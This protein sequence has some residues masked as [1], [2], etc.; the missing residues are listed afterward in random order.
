MTMTRI[1][2][3]PAKTVGLDSPPMLGRAAR[4]GFILF[5][6][7]LLNVFLPG[8]TRGMVTL[9]G[10]APSCHEKV[11]TSCCSGGAKTADNKGEPTSSDRARC[12]VCFFAARVC[13]ITPYE[14]R[15]TEMGLCEILPVAQPIIAPTIALH[16]PYLGRAPPIA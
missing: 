13:T 15:L 2:L 3:D 12:A 6:F 9:P 11:A 8:H 10:S 16:R 1:E 7:V 14:F 4:A 5:Q